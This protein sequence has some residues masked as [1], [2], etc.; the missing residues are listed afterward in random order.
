V[1]PEISPRTA[2][3]L[4]PL[5]KTSATA[6]H[7]APTAHIRAVKPRDSELDIDNSSTKNIFISH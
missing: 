4:K 7:S 1:K 5:S 2:T 6:R 3:G